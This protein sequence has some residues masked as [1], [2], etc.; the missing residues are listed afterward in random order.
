ML[1]ENVKFENK[2]M[3]RAEATGGVGENAWQHAQFF[4]QNIHDDSE[5]SFE[6][7]IEFMKE[8]DDDYSISE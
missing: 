1:V 4:R 6:V 2:F 7:I 3:L 8:G 5:Y